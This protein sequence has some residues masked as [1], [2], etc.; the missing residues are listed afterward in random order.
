MEKYRRFA[1]PAALLLAV[2]IAVVLIR[3]FAEHHHH[4]SATPGS[5]I[6]VT[7]KRKTWTVKAGDTLSKI[8]A[9]SGIP[10][11]TIRRLNPHVTATNLFI[12]EKL[13][14]R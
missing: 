11:A 1:G 3:L 4:P 12:G 2:T 14:L 13:K 9:A 6:T 8:S 10:L 5:T 7:L